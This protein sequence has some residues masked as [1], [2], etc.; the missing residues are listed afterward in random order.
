MKD[1]VFGAGSAVYSV[2]RK[3]V[4]AE[5]T[6]NVRGHDG[7]VGS[8]PDARGRSRVGGHRGGAIERDKDRG[9]GLILQHQPL[10]FAGCIDEGGGRCH[11]NFCD[12][13]VRGFST[14]FRCS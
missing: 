8:Q 9:V 12:H 13:G 14:C 10:S 4:A 7:V 1:E 3:V 5:P 6:G 11:G 2:D